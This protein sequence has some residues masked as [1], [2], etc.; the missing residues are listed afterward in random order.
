QDMS[1]DMDSR[2]KR[3][4]PTQVTIDGRQFS[5]EQAEKN[6]FEA[7]LALFRKSNFKAADQAF[8]KFAKT[9]PESPYLPTAL[10]WQGGAQYAQGNYNGAVNTLQSLIQR[11]PDSA[12]KADA[13][14]LIGNAQVDAGN[15]K[16]ARQTFIRIGKEHPNTPAANAARERLK[17]M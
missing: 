1:A 5:V 2:L 4:E 12:R 6:E 15:D 3:F 9:Y 10:Y 11:F 14:L 7:A 16:A 17:A 8:A 13:L